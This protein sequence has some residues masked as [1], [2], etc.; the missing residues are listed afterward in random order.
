MT[1]RAPANPGVER[2]FV[3]VRDASA[4]SGLSQWTWRQWAYVGRVA[5]V[6]AGQGRRARLLIPLSEIDRIMA[7]GL[8]PAVP[9]ERS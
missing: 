6:K 5:S 3:T 2:K 9:E 1:T 8:R 7:K 4:I